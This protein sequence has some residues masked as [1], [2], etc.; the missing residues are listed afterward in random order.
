MA[1]NGLL[2]KT[3]KH[4]HPD[5]N[6]QTRY[7]TITSLEVDSVAAI[8]EAIYRTILPNIHYGYRIGSLINKWGALQ[9]H[10]DG[11]VDVVPNMNDEAAQELLKQEDGE[12]FQRMWYRSP[13]FLDEREGG[14]LGLASWLWADVGIVNA[15]KDGQRFQ[16]TGSVLFTYAPYWVMP[17]S[18]LERLSELEDLD[19]SSEP[20]WFAG[21]HGLCQESGTHHLVIYTGDCVVVGIFNATFDVIKFSTP[22]RVDIRH[23]GHYGYGMDGTGLNYT[24]PEE[25]DVCLFQVLTQ[26]MADARASQVVH[27][28]APDAIVAARPPAI[29]TLP[30]PFAPL[31]RNDHQ[32]RASSTKAETEYSMRFSGRTKYH[33]P[34]PTHKE[35]RETVRQA[36]VAKEQKSNQTAA[37]AASAAVPRASRASAGTFR[38]FL[39]F[40]IIVES[41]PNAHLRILVEPPAISVHP[42]S[43]SSGGS[44]KR[45]RDDESTL[46]TPPQTGSP[47]T[48]SPHIGGSPAPYLRPRPTRSTRAMPTQNATAGP[49]RKRRISAAVTKT[50]GDEESSRPTKRTR[51]TGPAA[52]AVV[53]AIVGNSANPVAGPSGTRQSA[54]QAAKHG[55]SYAERQAKL[56]DASDSKKRA[57]LKEKAK[58]VKTAVAAPKRSAMI[59]IKVEEI[60]EDEDDESVYGSTN[61]DDLMDVDVQPEPVAVVVPKAKRVAATTTTTKQTKKAVAVKESSKKAA[62]K[63]KA[64]AKGNAKAAVVGKSQGDGALISTNVRYVLRTRSI[65]VLATAT[66]GEAEAAVVGGKGKGRAVPTRRT[67]RK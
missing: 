52:T 5:V 26:V 66:N 20:S 11:E 49:S 8:H 36:K 25:M 65:P 54:R 60:D 63:A 24:R 56:A 34:Y 18:E 10:P 62:V 19:D 43:S 31:T 14:K 58:A 48:N 30:F 27:I 32:P 28:P 57:E 61:A 13:I 59:V 41:V 50:K 4:S 9:Q 46:L 40:V 38:F 67:T 15:Q 1:A 12:A 42:P 29:A 2:P 33:G 55:N 3:F 51:T 17:E 45:Q 23:D 44:L 22:L 21:I 39:H 35:I 37:P 6:P 7:P 16:A 53:P 47:R 64:K